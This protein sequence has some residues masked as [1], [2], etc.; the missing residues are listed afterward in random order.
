MNAARARAHQVVR[1]GVAQRE[2]CGAAARGEQRLEGC[3]TGEEGVEVC[4][5]RVDNWRR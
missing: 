2:S 1:E 5:F 3:V 4:G